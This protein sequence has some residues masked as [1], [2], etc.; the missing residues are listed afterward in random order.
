MGGRISIVAA[1]AAGLIASLVGGLTVGK[2]N[3]VYDVSLKGQ[4]DRLKDK[5][6][7]R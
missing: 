4:L 3:R 2:G 5:I 6:S 7:E 1:L